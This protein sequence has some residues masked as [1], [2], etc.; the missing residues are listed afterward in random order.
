M[1]KSIFVPV[2]NSDYSNQAIS[3][4]VEVGKKYNSRLT[5]NHVYAAKMHDYRFKQ[6]EFT[7]PDEYL[8][9]TELERQRKIHDSLI[10]MGLKL[11]SDC[12]LTEMDK[13]C[14]EAGLELEKK[15]MDGK[16]HEQILKDM[17][18]SE[19]D[20]TVLGIKGIGKTKDS[21]IGA[22]CQSV[23]RHGKGDIWVVK[24]LPVDDEP[25]RD[26]ILV[27]VD[28]SPQSF[29]GL[30]TAV[31]L[32]KEFNK[33]ITLIGVYDPYLHYM[34]FNGIVDVLTDKAAKVFRFEEQNQL[35]EEII[36]TGLAQIYQS[37]LEV[38]E[39]MLK[40]KGLE[41]E[42]VLLDGKAFQKILDYTRKNPPWLLIVGRIGVHSDLE[43][44][45][46]GSNTDNLLRIAP[47]DVLLNS[48]LV[49]P[50]LDRKAE[51]SIQW[52]QEAEERMTRVPPL[53]KGIA[54]T[55]IL[56]LAVEKGHSV[57]TNSL[58]DEAMDRFM[59]KQAAKAT[60]KLA[61][62]LAFN[63]ARKGNTAICKSCGMTAKEENPIKCAVCGSTNFEVITPK[64]IDDIIKSEGGSNEETSYD[65]RK[66][67]WTKE[68]RKLLPAIKDNYQKRRAKAYIEKA[69]RMRRLNAVTVEFAEEIIKE[70][71]HEDSLEEHNLT[72]SSSNSASSVEN[73]FNDGIK[74]IARDKKG[75]PL[76]S[77]YDWTAE[78]SE[79]ILRVP[80]GFMR[81]KVQER[82]ESIAL[83]EK[84][85]SIDIGLV[86]KGIEI[87]RKMM[88]EMITAQTNGNGNSR[89]SGAPEYGSEEVN[90][91][92]HDQ[93]PKEN[94]NEVSVMSELESKR[95]DL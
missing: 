51:E 54:R 79:R 50:E 37:H 58:I 52:T 22:V 66:L 92:P 41:A 61:E 94:L 9:E 82:I 39:K 26:T 71:G 60:D 89:M 27:G 38:A 30:M 35:H 91:Y 20:L 2:D 43:D 77:V 34:V 23:T 84:T 81:D 3:V 14:E 16:H 55:G 4:A 6:M 83:E 18:A 80:A 95:S 57:V 47:C 56:R 67:S 75:T 46:L 93:P 15:M 29:G 70:L 1:F 10:T 12:Y 63:M 78:A 24:H 25:E 69:A 11:I 73:D 32:A 68:A 86:E 76:K 90:D 45:G 65:G 87:G 53:V 28:G 36:D 59:P 8:Q 17:E 88:E 13:H 7:L 49:Y 72:A 40:E 44:T 42:K 33:K 19:Y 5:G 85:F 62:T 21:Q 64:I 31:E 48:R 74:L